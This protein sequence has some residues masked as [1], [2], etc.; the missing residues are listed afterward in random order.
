MYGDKSPAGADKK[1]H[2]GNMAHLFADFIPIYATN[3]FI[4]LIQKM[5]QWEWDS[6]S[7]T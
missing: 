7:E 3:H 6:V 4:R 1:Q 5:F 2:K